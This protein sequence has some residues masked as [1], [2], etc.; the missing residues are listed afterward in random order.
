MFIAYHAGLNTVRD[1]ESPEDV[2]GSG[3]SFEEYDGKLS[4]VRARLATLPSAYTPGIPLT[5]DWVYESCRIAA[6]IYTSAMILRVPFS[7][8]A[9]PGRS[10][11]LAD[12]ASFTNSSAG[13][14]LL[15]TRLAHALYETLERTNLAESW[16]SM[17]GV[18]YWVAA[19]GAAAARTPISITMTRTP[20]SRSEAYDVW[21][22][23]CLI[24]VATRA[25][26]LLLFEYPIPMVKAQ[27]KLLKV[28]ELIGHE[29]PR[30]LIS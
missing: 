25:V 14:H 29:R 5:G 28:Q 26:V 9:S 6:I 19:V 11:I 30:R 4:E 13:G 18:L 12:M 10:P 20:R 23:R 24:M 7:E 27:K 16:G 17:G 3:P 2:S 1:A 21:V 8:A 22:R 15:S